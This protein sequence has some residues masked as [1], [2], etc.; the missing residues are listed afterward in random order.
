MANCTRCGK[1]TSV[2]NRDLATDFF[3]YLSPHLELQIGFQAHGF[4]GVMWTG[5]GS[6]V[7]AALILARLRAPAGERD[8][9]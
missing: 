9:A 2:W 1:P 3:G 6:P 4:N 7:W 8:D 5:L